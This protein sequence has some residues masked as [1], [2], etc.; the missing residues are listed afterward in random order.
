MKKKVSSTD[1][2][3]ENTSTTT[4]GEVEVKRRRRS[5]SF[6][7]LLKKAD[8]MASGINEHLE[9][10]STRGL[11]EE[12]IQG[13]RKYIDDLRLLDS[14]QEIHKGKLKEKTSLLYKNVKELKDLLHQCTLIVKADIPQ[15]RWVGFGM[16][17]KK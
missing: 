1:A 10:L 17:A 12:T 8:N 14:E 15:K 2:A 16:S 4:N 5:N 13:I 9:S 6:A 7:S 3:N 11:N